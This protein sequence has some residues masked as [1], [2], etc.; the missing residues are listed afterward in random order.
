[1]ST[2]ISMERESFFFP[3]LQKATFA[4]FCWLFQGNRPMLCAFYRCLQS[5]RLCR[6]HNFHAGDAKMKFLSRLGIVLL[7]LV[8]LY[9]ALL[10]KTGHDAEKKLPAVSQKIEEMYPYF[11][12]IA[13]EYDRGI[14]SSKEKVSWAF[15]MPDTDGYDAE[16]AKVP[17]FKTETLVK[18]GPFPGFCLA[19]ATTETRFLA[20]DDSIQQMLNQVWKGQDPLV[21]KTRIPI[22]GSS[23]VVNMNSPELKFEL[24]PGEG[25]NWEGLNMDMQVDKNLAGYTYDASMPG[26]KVESR[27]EHV[28]FSG[29]TASGEA[30]RPYEE[31]PYF[32][33]GKEQ[34]SI[35]KFQM[36]MHKL[37]AAFNLL[38]FTYGGDASVAND[39]LNANIRMGAGRLNVL[40]V[41]LENL[42]LD[43]GMDAIDGKAYARLQSDLMGF[44]NSG[45][46]AVSEPDAYIN[47]ITDRFMAVFKEASTLQIRNLSAKNDGGDI[48]MSG[49]F[50]LAPIASFVKAYTIARSYYDQPADEAVEDVIPKISGNMSL[51]ATRESL[52]ILAGETGMGG[53]ES[54]GSV[55]VME[56][57]LDGFIQN[58]LVEANGNIL[59]TNVL[60]K[61]GLVTMNGVTLDDAMVEKIFGKG[62][63]DIEGEEGVSDGG[64]P[65]VGDQDAASDARE[66][67]ADARPPE[68]EQ[69]GDPAAAKPEAG[70]EVVPEKEAAP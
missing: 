19:L 67:E 39:L 4:I 17:I 45:L 43:F 48:R 50:D 47:E 31:F 9:G 13:R 40:G 15:V 68:G 66:A 24:V 44:S 1:M 22:F 64:T 34:G 42:S 60:I 28:S 5:F 49:S 12:V 57:I 56:T 23:V 46:D 33:I 11:S 27:S 65:E 59:K 53:A 37:G 21:I 36:D 35:G 16:Y 70:G 20:Y 25:L 38:D 63:G 61:D 29:L 10:W 41:G 6:I 54:G 18:H 62:D 26:F 69:D 7:V 51:E 30:T 2:F 52:L 14:F 3:T 8:V 55:Q 58:A 32:F